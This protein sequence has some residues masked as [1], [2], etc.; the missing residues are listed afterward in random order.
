MY[1][2]TVEENKREVT[3][4]LVNDEDMPP[5]IITMDD[6]DIPQVVIN[7]KCSI[8]LSLYRKCIGGCA[9][10]LYDKIDELLTSHLTEQRTF[11][12]ME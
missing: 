5:I 6:N 10:S 4:K 12:L 11:E 9:H 2:E 1:N 8:W 7:R 3:F